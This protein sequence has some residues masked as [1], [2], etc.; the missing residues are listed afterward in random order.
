MNKLWG[1][2]TNEMYKQFK[3]PA[4][5]FLS[6]FIVMSGFFLPALIKIAMSFSSDTVSEDKATVEAQIDYRRNENKRLVDELNKATTSNADEYY[7]DDLQWQLQENSRQLF[8]AEV[9]LQMEL[10]N[11]PSYVMTDSFIPHALS[12]LSNADEEIRALNSIE[13][14]E[15]DDSWADALEK[16]KQNYSILMDVIK[17]K[18]FAAYNAYQLDG[19]S[20]LLSFM[21]EYELTPRVEALEWLPTIDPTGG[22][23][24]KIIYDDAMSLAR[25]ASNL[26]YELENNVE[27]S[28][29]YIN[30]SQNILVL[31]EDK[32]IDKQHEYDILLYKIN[33]NQVAESLQD[34]NIAMSK[35]VSVEFSNFFVSILIFLAAGSIVSSELSSGSIKMLI[36]APVRRWKIHTGKFLALITLFFI[37]L[38]LLCLATNIGNTVFMEFKGTPYLFVNNGEVVSIPY[39]IY[40]FIYLVVDH[41]L[42]FVLMLLAFMLSTL[43]RH[44]AVGIAVPFVLMMLTTWV[45]ML[46]MILPIGKKRWM[47]FLYI[48]N[49]DLSDR[50]F[51]MQKFFNLSEY[52]DTSQYMSHSNL[53][54]LSFSVI[55]VLIL[56]ACLFYIGFDSFTR[57]DIK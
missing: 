54:T 37:S 53:P 34:P 33:N 25:Y 21:P 24:G 36:V 31:S 29:D 16:E 35:N 40:D 6:L 3:R 50:V 48:Y 47:D 9:N 8:L 43:S 38:F 17:N 15:R 13:E 26:K 22:M 55:Y 27:F 4:V 19:Y 32:R 57:K 45:N 12:S 52:I 39:F 5:I 56:C 42:L 51:P 30:E 1:V 44:S 11:E 7:I 41:T 2:Y 14:S 10:Y 49:T 23:D 46:L 20:D 18:D 28:N